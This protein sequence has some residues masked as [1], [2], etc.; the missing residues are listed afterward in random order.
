[1]EPQERIA[2]LK[3]VGLLGALCE[4]QSLTSGDLAKASGS[5]QQTAS[6][7]LIELANAGLIERMMRVRRP[8]IRVTKAGRDLLRRE[9]E[10]YARL[11]LMEEEHATR[12]VEPVS[13]GATSG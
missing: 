7:V 5:S 6:R 10:G 9:F 13:G 12:Q 11:M 4:W 8:R 3:N 2:Y 1:M